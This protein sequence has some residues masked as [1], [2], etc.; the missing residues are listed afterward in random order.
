MQLHVL[1]LLAAGLHAMTMVPPLNPLLVQV[2][3]HRLSEA[4]QML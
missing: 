3:V 1:L 4:A 2:K